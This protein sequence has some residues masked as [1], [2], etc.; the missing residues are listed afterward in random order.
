MGKKRMS[1]L[2]KGKELGEGY[3]WVCIG[4]W[5]LECGWGATVYNVCVYV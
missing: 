4:C 2:T 5:Q 1:S 3:L